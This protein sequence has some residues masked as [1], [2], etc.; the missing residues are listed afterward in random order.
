MSINYLVL[1]L[2]YISICLEISGKEPIIRDNV[3]NFSD[4][5]QEHD[6]H[7]SEE[8]SNQSQYGSSSYFE[9]IN[10]QL[11]EDLQFLNPY[12]NRGSGG[13]NVSYDLYKDM[14][15]E[16]KQASVNVI[17]QFHFLHSFNYDVEEKKSDKYVVK[18]IQYGNECQ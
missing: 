13:T 2:N 10:N 16:S 4:K 12:Q 18:C 15:F 1:L 17:K 3:I 9:T 7:E 6:V 11:S 5:D 14:S 8:P